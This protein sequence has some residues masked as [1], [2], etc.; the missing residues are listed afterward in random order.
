VKRRDIAQSN[1]RFA[2]ELEGHRRE[3]KLSL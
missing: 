1:E 3:L 2:I